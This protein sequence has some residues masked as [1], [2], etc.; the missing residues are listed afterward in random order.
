MFRQL[1]TWWGSKSRRQRPASTRF[2]PRLEQLEDRCTPTVIGAVGSL[3]LGSTTGTASP[4]LIV[5]TEAGVQTAVQAYYGSTYDFN[6]QTGYTTGQL[7]LNQQPFGASTGGAYVASADINNDGIDDVLVGSGAGQQAW[8]TIYDG[9]TQAPLFNQAVF[10]YDPTYTGGV[11]VAAADVTT[12]GYAT[13]FVGKA[14]GA[15]DV[16]VF[17]NTNGSLS[18][19][20]NFQAFGAAPG[21]GT[22]GV[23]LA[24]GKFFDQEGQGTP[25]LI[26]GAGPGYNLA[27][28]VKMYSFTNSAVQL[29]CSFSAPLASSTAG[30]QVTAIT[31]KWTAGLVATTAASAESPKVH[32]FSFTQPNAQGDFTAQAPTT[33]ALAGVGGISSSGV[34]RIVGGGFVYGGTAA[35]LVAELVVGEVGQNT[36]NVVGIEPDGTF[37]TPAEFNASFG[38]L[39]LGSLTIPYTGTVTANGNLLASLPVLSA[40]PQGE[41]NE[42]ANTSLTMLPATPV[43]YHT[44][45]LLNFNPQFIQTGLQDGFG[46]SPWNDPHAWGNHPYSDWYLP[47][48]EP[49]FTTWG[50]QQATFTAPAN[51]DQMS[52]AW[53]AQRVIYA[54]STFLDVTDY[55]HHH[56]PSWIAPNDWPYSPV[57]TRL[58]QG[59]GIDCSDFTGFAFRYGLGIDLLTGT[60][61]QGQQT[62]ATL[63]L[64]DGTTRQLNFNVVA[65]YSPSLTFNQLVN[66]LQAGDLLYLVANPGTQA[67]S[68]AAHVIIWLGTVGIDSNGQPVNLIMDSTGFGHTDS[69]NISVPEGVHIRPFTANMWYFDAFLLARRMQFFAPP[70]PAAVP[71]A[72][73]NIVVLDSIIDMLLR[74]QSVPSVNLSGILPSSAPGSLAATTMQPLLLGNIASA[75]TDLGFPRERGDTSGTSATAVVTGQILLNDNNGQAPGTTRAAAGLKLVLEVD[76]GDGIFVPIATTIT[77]EFGHYSFTGLPAGNYRVRA[78]VGNVI[79]TT[80]GADRSSDAGTAGSGTTALAS[81]LQIQNAPAIHDEAFVDWFR[82]WLPDVPLEDWTHFMKVSGQEETDPFEMLAMVPPVEEPSSGREEAPLAAVFLAGVGSGQCMVGSSWARKSLASGAAAVTAGPARRRQ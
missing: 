60:S 76:R 29:H 57:S 39:A 50:P 18:S 44:P 34:L 16:E 78:A 33:V 69:N 81:R 41:A 37:L 22:G 11:Q 8:L 14:T 19:A 59:P 63:N 38:S 53:L 49:V 61:E 9:Q 26:V 25:Y 46:V 27:N 68:G 20:Y 72:I 64:A 56:V 32:L 75:R 65:E 67:T 55:Q 1:F 10:T 6:L 71:P 54:G 12:D 2:Q 70:T 28:N 51:Y 5:A 47:Q 4:N 82:D 36:V 7:V 43:D 21:S 3:A 30:V 66:Q 77:D 23:S 42:W 52:S 80:T 79:V 15:S 48:M 17:Q 31:G 13:V 74:E 45:Y 35:P 58:Y 73:P 40:D 24:V 62:Q